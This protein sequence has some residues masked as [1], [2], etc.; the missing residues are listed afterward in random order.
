MIPMHPI[1]HL[2]IE[3]R[4]GNVEP[5]AWGPMPNTDLG[6]QSPRFWR[7]FCGI[8]FLGLSVTKKANKSPSR[9]TIGT[10]KNGSEYICRSILK[11]SNYNVFEPHL[12]WTLFVQVAVLT[13]S[14]LTLALINPQYFLSWWAV[15]S[16]RVTRSSPERLL[17][18]R[19]DWISSRRSFKAGSCLEEA[20]IDRKRGNTRSLLRA[21][22][23]TSSRF[24]TVSGS[25]SPPPS[26]SRALT[27]GRRSHSCP[28]P[29]ME[30]VAGG[31]AN[32]PFLF[33]PFPMFPNKLFEQ[34]EAAV[35]AVVVTSPRRS[36]CLSIAS[37]CFRGP[38]LGMDHQKRSHGW[39]ARCFRYIELNMLFQKLQGYNCS[40]K[41]SNWF[42][43]LPKM[44][45]KNL[46]LLCVQSGK[47]KSLIDHFF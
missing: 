20:Y 23:F 1:I 42:S 36:W 45:S 10:S 3:V 15:S 4:Q 46:A 32:F 17:R 8:I 34:T 25:R 39:C 41:N 16:I 31:L 38:G 24:N 11:W 9:I 47:V 35:P 28:S 30:H 26:R 12:L 37:V 19:A 44:Q 27:C 40:P 29:V 21:Q 2:R 33:L 13:S 5:E 43:V 7:V 6:S 22:T 14:L 18:V